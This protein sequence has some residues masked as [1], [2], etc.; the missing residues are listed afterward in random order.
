MSPWLESV[1]REWHVLD[2]VNDAERGR[3]DIIYSKLQG[4]RNPYID[5]S[6]WVDLVDF[7]S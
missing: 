2:P 4:N 6:E 5:H 3:N 7:S 1:M